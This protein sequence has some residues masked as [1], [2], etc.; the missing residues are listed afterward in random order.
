MQQAMALSGVDATASLAAGP[1]ARIGGSTDA[2]ERLLV[3]VLLLLLLLWEERR[4]RQVPGWLAGWLAGWLSGWLAAEHGMR[5]S[6]I[7][8][9]GAHACSFVA[10]ASS[11]AFIAFLVLFS[12]CYPTMLCLPPV[13]PHPSG[14]FCRRLWP[15]SSRRRHPLG[16]RRCSRRWCL[17]LPGTVA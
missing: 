1:Y 12:C 8:S 3:L 15:H 4:Q 5:S 7:A 10:S 17:Q 14:P 6:R 16:R 13:H 2:G 11:N 9:R